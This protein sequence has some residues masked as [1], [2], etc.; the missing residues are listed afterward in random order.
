LSTK[1]KINNLTI[2]WKKI[3]IKKENQSKEKK[4]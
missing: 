2:I 1:N 3:K 4:N